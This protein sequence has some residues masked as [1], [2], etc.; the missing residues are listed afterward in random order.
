MPGLEGLCM[1]SSYIAMASAIH[2]VLAGHPHLETW[3][4]RKN[5]EISP[6][7]M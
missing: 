1:I 4:E 6:K 3:T 2:V 5:K 7:H